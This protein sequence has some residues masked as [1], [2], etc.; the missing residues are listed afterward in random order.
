MKPFDKHYLE[1]EANVTNKTKPAEPKLLAQ[2]RIIISNLYDYIKNLRTLE[3]SSIL[4]SIH[5]WIK[6]KGRFS[7]RQ[8]QTRDIVVADL[9]L[10]Y[11]YEM[12]YRHPCIVLYDSKAGFCFVVP[13]STGKYGKNNKYILDGEVSDGFAEPTGVLLDAAR[14]I[15]KVRIYNKVGRITVPFLDKLKNELL[16]LYFSKQYNQLENQE[17][18]IATLTADNEVLEQENEILKQEIEKLKQKIEEFA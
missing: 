17:K 3:L 13:C 15:S 4:L 1:S 11:G 14:C 6:G 16:K 12:S 5:G 18:D 10:G 2:C 8:F 7:S 9:G